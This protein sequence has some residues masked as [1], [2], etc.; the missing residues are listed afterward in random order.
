MNGG[1]D[2]PGRKEWITV[3][4]YPAGQKHVS[5]VSVG[6]R[7]KATRIR[8]VW[9]SCT[10]SVRLQMEWRT[11]SWWIWMAP[12]NRTKPTKDIAP[13]EENQP[14]VDN[15]FTV[16]IEGS[17][18]RLVGGKL[19]ACV[20]H[21][22]TFALFAKKV[23]GV[24]FCLERGVYCTLWFFGEIFKSFDTKN[25]VKRKAKEALFFDMKL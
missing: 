11:G 22:W 3:D 18:G 19:R 20:N 13:D 15:D 4:R 10:L 2:R 25:W 24:A 5:K 9:P 12:H 8:L 7:Q 17:S 6:D 14:T 21:T 1:A 23:N 16:F